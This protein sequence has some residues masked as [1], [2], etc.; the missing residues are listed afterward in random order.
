M[1][2]NNTVLLL[3]NNLELSHSLIIDLTTCCL[4]D[5][6]TTSSKGLTAIVLSFDFKQVFDAV[7][8]GRLV[9]SLGEQGWPSYLCDWVAS[10]AIERWFW[11]LFDGEQGSTHQIQCGLH[12]GFPIAPILFTL[13][14]SSLSRLD[15][16]KKAFGY[17]DDVAIMATST[18][19]EENSVIIGTTFDRVLEC[20]LSEGLTFDPQKSQ[21]IH[22]R[23]VSRSKIDETFRHG[24]E[25]SRTH[26]SPIYLYFCT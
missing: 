1:G 5:I 19:L 3:G 6:E 7:M 12:H 20:G 4:H 22:L 14:R 10:F 17:T 23:I 8:P 21:L 25:K 2:Y 15:R 9:Q 18:S 26:L 16:F 13:H 24:S 11:I